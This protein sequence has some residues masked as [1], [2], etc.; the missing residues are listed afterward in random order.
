MWFHDEEDRDVDEREPAVTFSGAVPEAYDQ[1][2]V[3]MIF[4]PYAA[5]LA[6]RVRE[7]GPDRLLEVAAGTGAV[8][9]ALAVTLPDTVSITATDLSPA[10]IQHAST[11]GVARPVEWQTA[12]VM[13]LP[14]PDAAFDVVVCQFGVMFLPDRAAG[15]REVFRVLRPGGWFLFNVWDRIEHNEFA[16]VVSSTLAELYPDDPPRFM[17]RTP[18]GYFR[19]DEI[20]A[21]L[22]AGGFVDDV[23]VEEVRSRSR[24][25]TSAEVAIAYLHGTPLRNA[26]EA[27]GPGHL[28]AATTAAEAA[29]ARA[30]GDTDLDAPIGAFVVTARAPGSSDDAG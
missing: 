27:R 1:H 18:H 26:V 23:R 7:L 8:T 25:A 5:D 20:R 16:H 10:M 21:D 2:L 4:E 24:A 14:F 9:R 11:R 22:A 17:E 30:F 28:A 6:Q 19:E 29:I 13:D 15:Y 12:D 3:P